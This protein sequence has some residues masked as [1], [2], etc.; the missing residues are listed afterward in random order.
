MF[1]TS[2]TYKLLDH[3]FYFLPST[4]ASWPL[5]LTDAQAM[6]FLVRAVVSFLFTPLPWE[7]T[8]LSELLFLPEHAVW[9]LMI[10]FA[11][12]GVVA[13]WQ[14]NRRMTG[15]L[16]M[17]IV[18]TAAAIAMTTGNV[19]TLLRLRGMVTPTSCVRRAGCAHRCRAA[20]APAARA[21]PGDGT[22]TMSVVDSQG[23]CSAGEPG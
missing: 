17:W 13:S 16:V 11:P 1:T 9:L 21:C 19:G 12:I 10:V 8:S 7:M 23:G 2:H 18:P 3:G 22:R 15:L 14:R 4:P 20:V 6:R 5:Q